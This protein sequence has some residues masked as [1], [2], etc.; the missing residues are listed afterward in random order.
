MIKKVNHIIRIELMII[1]KGMI[2][3]FRNYMSK[4]MK[5][6]LVNNFK[7]FIKHHKMIA[8]NLSEII[9]ST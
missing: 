5:N 9:K 2:K 8:L 4:N 1:I 6:L 3:V 7:I